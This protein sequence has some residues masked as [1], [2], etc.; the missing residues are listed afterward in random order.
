MKCSVDRKRQRDLTAKDLGPSGRYGVRLLRRIGVALGSAIL[1]AGLGAAGWAS[2]LAETGNVHT[3]LP[4]QLYR[5]AE[6]SRDGFE[7][8]ITRLHIHTVINL[9]GADPGETWYEN[10]LA[11]VSATGVRHV[12]FRMSATHVPSSSKLH[13][14]KTILATAEPPILI[15]CRS[16]ADR[17]GLVAALYEFWIAH[18]PPQEA[19]EQLSFRYGHFPWLGNRTIAMDE[20]WQNAVRKR[21]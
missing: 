8:V 14:I 17:S 10:E 21:P 18:R 20:A 6:L 12:D 3:V 5:S 15:H 13:E 7:R 4:G 16:G 9:R 1:I 2:Y 19:T 11:A